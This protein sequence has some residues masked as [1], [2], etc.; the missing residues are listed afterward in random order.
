M[1]FIN[2]QLTSISGDTAEEKVMI[3]MF[4]KWHFKCHTSVG[5]WKD[6]VS[7]PTFQSERT[8]HI[9][10]LSFYQPSLCHIGPGYHA[11]D[12]ETITMVSHYNM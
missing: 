4:W 9:Q 6:F 3:K 5:L 2:V 8:L 10:N 11:A 12:L 7:C 1:I